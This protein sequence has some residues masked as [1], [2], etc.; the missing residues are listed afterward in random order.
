MAIHLGTMSVHLGTHLATRNEKPA[1]DAGFKLEMYP[2]RDLNPH[3]R[4]A[5]GF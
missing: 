2:G 1:I 4:E 3:G 5:T